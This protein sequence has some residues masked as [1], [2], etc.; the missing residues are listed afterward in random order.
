MIAMGCV[1][2]RKCHLNN[3]PVGVATTD[4]K[5]RSKFKGEVEHVV[6]FFNAVSQ[7]AREIMASL[8]ARKLTDLIGRPDLIGI[9][10]VEGHPKANML[11]FSRL[12]KDVNEG[13]TKAMPRHRTW[14]RND[15]LH[16]APLDDKIIQDA[17]DAIAN[18]SP[19]DFK[20][21]H[22]A[23]QSVRLVGYRPGLIEFNPA[24]GAPPDLANRLSQILRSA[25]GARWAVIVSDKA[26]Q[27]TIAEARRAADEA[28][29]REAEDHP[30]V[31]AAL[32]TFPGAVISAVKPLKPL[33]QPEV[34]AAVPDADDMDADLLDED[35]P[36]E[37]EF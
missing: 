10:E 37:E 17:R 15:G 12:L 20:L 22:A 30:L 14:E 18:K 4:P 24:P 25:T 32:A 31:A 34:L 6:N 21:H 27:S 11:D 26:G 7:D 3:C 19:I 23:E 35:D 33:P 9:R 29:K 16:E 2:V 28:A 36:F 5:Y 13:A 8:G 1:Y